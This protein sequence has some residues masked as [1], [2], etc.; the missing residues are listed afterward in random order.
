[1]SAATA[2]FLGSGRRVWATVAPPTTVNPACNWWRDLLQ[3]RTMGPAA[4]ASATGQR[5][6]SLR[7]SRFAGGLRADLIKLTHPAP[8]KA[9]P[10]QS[11]TWIED[12]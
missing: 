10:P 1:M 6:K 11:L 3:L 8:R 9:K 2:A 5:T 7:D 12:H 4:V